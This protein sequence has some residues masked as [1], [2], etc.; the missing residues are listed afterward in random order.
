MRARK[1]CDVVLLYGARAYISFF[2][3]L[4][5]VLAG[6]YMTDIVPGLVPDPN[7]KVAV[8]RKSGHVKL[9]DYSV[10]GVANEVTFGLAWEVTDGVNIDLDASAIVLNAQLGSVDTIWYRNL[11]Q[12]GAIRHCGDEREGDA[13]GDDE[14]IQLSLAA[15]APEARYIAFCINSVC[16]I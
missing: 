12:G 6:R 14:K 3:H 9:N 16:L 4:A 5:V 10:G 1:A 15:V 11:G 2:F 8:M 7:A 13:V